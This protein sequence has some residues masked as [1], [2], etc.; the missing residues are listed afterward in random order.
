[1]GGYSDTANAPMAMNGECGYL[2]PGQTA[3]CDGVAENE[4]WGRRICF[5]DLPAAKTSCK[6]QPNRTSV[7]Q[8]KVAAGTGGRN[9]SRRVPPCALTKRTRSNVRRPRAVY[10]TRVTE[11]ARMK[12]HKRTDPSPRRSFS[13]DRATALPIPFPPAFFFSSL[14]ECFIYCHPPPPP[15]W[16]QRGS[17]LSK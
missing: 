16:T 12:E 3:T 4:I 11:S 15:R 10:S 14:V 5:C 9:A 1:M 7:W 2:D 13:R 17:V 8:L 6:P